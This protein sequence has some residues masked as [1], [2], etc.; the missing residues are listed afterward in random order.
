VVEEMKNVFVLLFLILMSSCAEKPISFEVSNTPI[1]SNKTESASAEKPDRSEEYYLDETRG[2]RADYF[3][4]GMHQESMTLYKT[5]DHGNTWIE[6]ANSKKERSTLPGG[7]KS[8][9]YFLTADKRWIT[10]NAPWQG[11]VGL[12]KTADG[13][14]SWSEQS[15]DVPKELGDSEIDSVP[16]FFFSESDGILITDPVPDDQNQ[17]FYI[18]HDGGER[19]I[20]FFNEAKG[21]DQDITWDSEKKLDKWVYTVKFKDKT[22]T[23]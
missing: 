8:G 5:G 9:I 18:T 2:W 1:S 19:W 10:S 17:L 22:W 16:P 23:L 6:I 7:V 15:L 3:F 4:I 14:V 11:K 12:F 13:G 20:P 21:S